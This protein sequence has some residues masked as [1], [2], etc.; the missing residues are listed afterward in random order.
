MVGLHRKPIAR[1]RLRRSGYSFHLEGDWAAELVELA[2]QAAGL[3]GPGGAFE[4]VLA[5]EAGVLSVAGD[6]C[7]TAVV[8]RG[9]PARAA[10]GGITRPALEPIATAALPFPPLGSVPHPQRT[11]ASDQ[12]GRGMQ[13]PL[14]QLENTN[15]IQHV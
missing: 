3:V 6:M 13:V 14:H 15:G 2:D 9:L 8:P 4:E 12:S 1:S 5:A 7:Q 10:H 11:T